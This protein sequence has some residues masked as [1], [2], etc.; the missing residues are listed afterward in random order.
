MSPLTVRF[1]DLDTLDQE[2]YYV[3]AAHRATRLAKEGGAGGPEFAALLDLLE[4]GFDG[5][6]PIPKILAMQVLLRIAPERGATLVARALDGRGALAAYAG[7]L[8]DG[9]EDRVALFLPALSSPE[10]DVSALGAASLRDP[11]LPRALAR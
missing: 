10:P 11:S 4:S 6:L 5:T 8:T 9:V 7:V 2:L 1:K 3:A